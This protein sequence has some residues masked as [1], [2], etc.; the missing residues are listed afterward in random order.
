MIYEHSMIFRLDTPPASIDLALAT[1]REVCVKPLLIVESDKRRMR[2]R[3]L[4]NHIFKV[5]RFEMEGDEALMEVLRERLW[6]DHDFIISSLTVPHPQHE[7]LTRFAPGRWAAAMDEMFIVA[8]D[9]PAFV[10]TSS[11]PV[12][13]IERVI[14]Q[15]RDRF[16]KEA[17][18]DRFLRDGPRKERKVTPP[19]RR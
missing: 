5:V 16:S 9:R 3:E 2:I 10:A 13:P 18:M 8:E 7:R 14:E 11:F 6:E 1:A 4:G 19:L 12:E 17:L 15:P